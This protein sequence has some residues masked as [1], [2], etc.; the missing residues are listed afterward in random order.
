MMI[1]P[2]YFPFTY[3]PQWVAEAF[4][5]SFK[6]FWVYQPSAKDLP[7]EMQTWV[8]KKAINVCVPV[9]AEDKKFAEV[10]RAFNRF[11]HLHVD[12]KNLRT[13]A[14]WNRDGA[15]PFFDETSASQI[16]ADLKKDPT[17]KTGLADLDSL[18]H[19]RVFLAFAQEFDRQNAEIQQ[20]LSMTDRHS[21]D[22]L[23]NLSGQTDEASAVTRLTTEIKVDDPGEYMA[24]DRLQTWIRLFMEKPI[25][26]GFL[27]T[28]S[29]S[30]FNDMIENLTTAEKLLESETLP[31]NAASDEATITRRETFLGRIKNLIESEVAAGE[32]IFAHEPRLENHTAQHRLTLYRLPGCNPAQLLTPLLTAPHR[33]ENKC[34]QMPEIKSTLLGLVVRSP[35]IAQNGRFD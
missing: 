6:Q 33:A 31:A 22:L 34:H 16:A 17:Q 32:D 5:H 13:V 3:V 26:S 21:K 19:A 15:V 8:D 2:I 35:S 27:V 30:I 4:A 28:S 18:L 12:G 1:E 14:F 7:A 11:A 29:P 25:D 20:E 23:K 24:Q 9:M 10:V